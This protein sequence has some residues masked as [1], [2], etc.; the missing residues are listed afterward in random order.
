MSFYDLAN[1]KDRERMRQERLAELQA[2]KDGTWP[3]DINDQMRWIA[4]PLGWTLIQWAEYMCMGELDYLDL[5]DKEGFGRE[6]I[7]KLEK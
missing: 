5:K 2:I 1:P 6:H 4:V 7:G 3:R